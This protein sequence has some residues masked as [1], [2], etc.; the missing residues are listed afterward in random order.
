MNN[1]T[2]I[3][4]S[5]LTAIGL[6]LIAGSAMAKKP[7]KHRHHRHDKK[8]DGQNGATIEERI[9]D[10]KDAHGAQ[11]EEGKDR[12]PTNISTYHNYSFS[13]IKALL[14]SGK[15][16][17]AQGTEYKTLHETITKSLIEAKKDAT[18][19]QREIKNLRGDLDL[20]NDVMS[21]VAGKGEEDKE[22]TPLLNNIQHRI[23][24]SIE[25]ALK[26]GRLSTL[27]A[28]GLKRKLKRLA[29]L[30]DRLKK[31]K[32]ITTKEREKLFDEVGEIRREI[33]KELRD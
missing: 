17:E 16:T 11:T 14:M 20:L 19:T 24:E 4:S 31:D 6:S 15:I 33:N 25:A 2:I 23:E 27:K 1:I 5:L 7:G 32:E 22:R 3:K 13:R 18:L 28:N 10:R 26:S 30:E 8:N 9:L 21:L 12:R 29:S